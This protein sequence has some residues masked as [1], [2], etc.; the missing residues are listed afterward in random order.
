[1][2]ITKTAKLKIY[3]RTFSLQP[4]LDI[5][6]QV[7]EYILSVVKLEKEVISTLSGKNKLNYLEKCIHK[8]TKNPEPKYSDFNEKFPKFPS[9]FRRACIQDGL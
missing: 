2:K 3:G 4:T 6:S 5:Y 9:Y 7:L 8:T 1:M